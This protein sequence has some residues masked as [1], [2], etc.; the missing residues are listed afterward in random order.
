MARPIWKGGISFGLVYIP[1]TLFS[2]EQAS[3]LHFHLLDSRNNAR[4]RYQKIN[5]QTGKEVP[6][7]KIVKGYEFEKN[8][9]IIIEESEFEKTASQ[10]P[11]V[12][13]IQSFVDQK[14]LPSV[15]F[16]KPYYL[17][18][19]KQGEKAYVLLREILLHTKKIAISKV[20]IRT[21][22]YLSVVMPYENSLVLN[23]LRF[24]EEIRE[25]GEFS[26]P[27]A[28]TKKYKIT[29]KELALA[30]QL[31][32]TMSGHW[33]PKEYKDESHEILMK[34]IEKSIKKRKSVLSPIADKKDLKNKKVNL[35]D[36]MT[37]LKKS[38][39]DKEEQKKCL[40]PERH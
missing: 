30:E 33:D 28:G 4:I 8:N 20:L 35:I 29:Q 9:Y 17:V 3:H 18:P 39:K 32:K 22:Q 19:T 21:K 7:E 37:V 26:M 11:Q 27:E 5:E 6:W 13:D 25:P 23:I 14:S 34:W 10:S 38:I 31:V 24:P 12:V 2:A 40:N 16:E 15:Y 1:V 36:F